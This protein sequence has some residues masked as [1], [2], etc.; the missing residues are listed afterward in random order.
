MLA[1]AKWRASWTPWDN[2]KQRMVLTVCYATDL[3]ISEAVRL[4]PA[5]IDSKRMVIRVEQGKGRKDRY[6]VLSAKLLDSIRYRCHPI[7]C[8]NRRDPI[9][10]PSAGT[11]YA[12]S[13][14][15]SKANENSLTA[16]IATGASGLSIV[17][18]TNV[19]KPTVLS[20]TVLDGDAVDVAV[21]EGNQIAVVAGGNAGLHIVDVSNLS[22]PKLLTDIPFPNPV[23]AVAVN[24]GVAY[25]AQGTGVT[26]VDLAMDT[27]LAT[28]DL[29]ATG[30][31]TL[32]GLALSGTT[33]VTMDPAQML[34][35][36]TVTGAVMTARGSLTLPAGSGNVLIGDHAAV[37]GTSG[38]S[39]AR[40][41]AQR[42][43]SEN[44]PSSAGVVRMIARSDHW[45]CVSTP[46]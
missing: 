37:A 34:H 46:R 18:L 15:G 21:D 31:T 26:M 6:V 2:L 17:D 5:A 3:R 10:S 22:A 11:A 27:V 39:A 28:L 42:V 41:C 25:V 1:R 32:T 4:T 33:L 20:T 45:R 12:I 24:D 13:A 35:A 7:T 16:Y 23:V 30:G 19:A 40:S 9:L 8:I 44:R 38:V 43:T 29:F 36:V 14:G